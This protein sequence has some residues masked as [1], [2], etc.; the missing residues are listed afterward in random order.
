MANTNTS[1]TFTL[2]GLDGNTIDLNA[3]IIDNQLKIQFGNNPLIEVLLNATSQTIN[4]AQINTWQANGAVLTRQ[5]LKKVF[6]RDDA[7]VD[8]KSN[9]IDLSKKIKRRVKEYTYIYSNADMNNIQRMSEDA[10]NAIIYYRD[11]IANDLLTD[12]VEEAKA[13]QLYNS[14]NLS[15]RSAQ[16]AK[17]TA[18]ATTITAIKNGQRFTGN[19]T[20][21]FAVPADPTK[22][23]YNCFK[24][25]EEAVNYLMRLGTRKSKKDKYY[26]HAKYGFNKSQIVIFASTEAI[27]YMRANSSKLNLFINANTQSKQVYN[28]H[29]GWLN[30]IEV[31]KC[32]ELSGNIEIMVSTKRVIVARE[33]EV[34]GAPVLTATQGDGSVSYVDGTMRSIHIDEVK[35]YGS[36]TYQSVVAFEGET[37]FINAA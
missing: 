30:G 13:Y 28:T 18:S 34:Q 36:Q 37:I 12:L 26:P 8:F 32:D 11:E 4:G 9:K 1:K 2:K 24:I 5:V 25:V 33:V 23:D 31:V 20:D 22:D 21:L 19:L 27:R 15:T 35:V 17:T 16:P 7:K 3:K 29:A 10:A 6:E 14:T